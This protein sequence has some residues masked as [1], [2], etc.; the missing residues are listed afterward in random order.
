MKATKFTSAIAIALLSST[1]LGFRLIAPEAT[2][3]L[4]RP[5]ALA[6]AQEPAARDVSKFNLGERNLAIE[7]YD[8]VAYFPEGGGSP[9]KGVEEFE[10]VYRG[11]LYRFASQKHLGLFKKTPG[12]YEP[13]YGGWCAFAMADGERVEIAPKSFHV[14]DDQLFLFFKSFFNDTRK[15]WLKDVDTLQP[16]A[17]KAWAEIL[18]AK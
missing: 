11:V 1:L 12:K 17:D 5:T 13:Q 18:K 15:K 10:L 8:P 2:P 9:L 4:D 14:E 7:G 3:D 16:K 6:A